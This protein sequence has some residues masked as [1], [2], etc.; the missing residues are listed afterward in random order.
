MSETPFKYRGRIF[1]ERMIELLKEIIATYREAHRRA[2]SKIVS[3][4]LDWRQQNGHQRDM[5]CRGAMLALHRLGRITLPPVRQA[6][7]NNAV[8]YRQVQ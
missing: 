1:D 3:E 7:R 2:L 4:V 6:S 8:R 5:V